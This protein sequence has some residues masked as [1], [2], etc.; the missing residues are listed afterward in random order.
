MLIIFT[1]AF[2]QA[3][4]LTPS[5]HAIQQP[6]GHKLTVVATIRP[7]HS[8]LSSIMQ[9]SDEPVLLLDQTQSVHHYSLRPSQRSTLTH[10]DMLFWVGE[11]L[12]GF[13]PRIINSL[14]KTVQVVELIESKGLSLLEPR[15]SELSGTEQHDHHG[16][17]HHDHGDNL[18]PHIWLSIDN[19]LIM[20]EKMAQSLALIA[21]HNKPL[22]D[23]NLQQL[24]SA[25]L[26]EKARIGQLFKTQDF[27][28]LVYHDAFQYFEE[29][30]QLKPLAAISNDEEQ[31]P[32]IKHLNKISQLI[33]THKI[34]CVIYNTPTLPAVARNLFKQDTIRVHID[35]VGQRFQAGPGLYFNLLNSLSAGYQQCQP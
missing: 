32:G 15:S 3:T 35:P 19:A 13:M 4:E 23:A 11:A 17:S 7:V 14:P 24:R 33:S 12:E 8:L 27:S 9:G 16:H 25:L 22:Y 21:P 29:P 20:A 2:A 30:L 5:G 31:A 34:S 10:A 18:D 6:G 28:Y 26:Q 1:S